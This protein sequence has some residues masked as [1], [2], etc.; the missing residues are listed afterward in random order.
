MKARLLGVLVV[1]A[2]A[3]AFA[4]ADARLGGGM[5][6]GFGRMGT[7]MSIHAPGGGEF[8]GGLNRPGQGG[9]GERNAGMRPGE[10]GGGERQPGMRPGQGGSGERWQPDPHPHPYPVPVPVPVV[11]EGWWDGAWWDWD[12]DPYWDGAVAT[13]VA[14]GAAAATSAAIGTTVSA[15]PANCATVFKN[16]LTFF[17]CGNVWYQPHYLG[18]G[19][20]YVVIPPP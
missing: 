16:D 3:L 1:S 7:A 2:G 12:A 11:P 17:Q 4:Q 14:I 20:A 6:G 5:R 13:G 8:R 18:T 15:L 9:A 19:V 10:G